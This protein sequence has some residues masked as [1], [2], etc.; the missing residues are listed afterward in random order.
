MKRIRKIAIILAM[1]LLV[2]SVMPASASNGKFIGNA[3]NSNVVHR[4]TCK[5]LPKEGN[6]IYFDTYDE[7]VQAGYRP[8]SKCNPQKAAS[9]DS[10]VSK[11][12]G[13]NSN[14]TSN[15]QAA[16]KSTPGKSTTV[17][18]KGVYIGNKNN[19]K[20]HRNTCKSLPAEK[21]RVYFD[22]LSEA[23]SAGYDDYC[24]NCMR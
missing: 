17:A 14:N 12:K 15:N 4:S 2:G 23:E 7:A 5:S 18:T 10:D 6:R 1:V 20:I 21:N 13:K 16:V 3:R 22:S 24:G 8:C 9:S 19:H 11:S